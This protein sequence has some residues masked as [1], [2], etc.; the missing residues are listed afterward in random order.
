ML[1][2]QIIVVINLDLRGRVRRSRS[3]RCRPHLVLSSGGERR[4]GCLR[5]CRR[6]G[7][8][9]HELTRGVAVFAGK[10]RIGLVRN[11]VAFAFLLGT[12]LDTVGEL[13]IED[14]LIL[15]HEPRN[16][17]HG[18]GLLGLARTHGS[19]YRVVLALLALL[20]GDKELGLLADERIR[21][22]AG[23]TIIV[24]LLSLFLGRNPQDV[25]QQMQ[26]QQEE[27]RRKRE[28]LERKRNDV[29]NKK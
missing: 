6:I 10:R 16:F 3:C 20:V 7:L 5:L 28:D 21:V 18:D 1:E 14:I 24:V 23:G 13:D 2:G 29:N 25:L 9:V 15:H 11:L 12:D 8:R 22:H 27:M 17:A 4:L 26:Q 19:D